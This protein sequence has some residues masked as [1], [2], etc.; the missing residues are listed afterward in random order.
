VDKAEFLR[1]S[2][3]YEKNHSLQFQKEQE[4]GARFRR[5][6]AFTRE[7][8]LQIVD[9]KFGDNEQKRSRTAEA[10]AKNDEAIVT[11]I[12][13]QVFNV[14]ETEDAFRMNSLTMLGGV[15]PILASVIL[16]FFDPKQYG[17]FDVQVWRELLGNEPPNLFSTQNY[18]KFLASLRKTAI[19]NNLDAR[20]VEKALFE[21]NLDKP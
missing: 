19:K 2:R 17:V 7:D 20:T 13:S 16:A 18:L 14:T 8:L 11:R 9:W 15:S 1:W 4:L 5:N 6:K 3:K 10:V 12:S 21:E